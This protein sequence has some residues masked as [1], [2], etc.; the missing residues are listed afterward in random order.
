LIQLICQSQDASSILLDSL[1]S[2]GN[3]S[4]AFFN[5]WVGN[6]KLKTDFL[7]HFFETKLG[8]AKLI[9]LFK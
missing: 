4:P 5:G 8:R 6:P 1:P 7:R 3:G 9:T 2:L